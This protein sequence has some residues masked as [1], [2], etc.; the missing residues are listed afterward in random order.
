MGLLL[1]AGQAAAVAARDHG[2]TLTIG[3]VNNMPDTAWEATERQFVALVR[4]AAVK[5][6]VRLQLFSITDLPRADHVRGELAARYHDLSALLS[7]RLDGLIV[8]GTEPRAANLKDEP[9]WVRLATLID[10]ARHHTGSTIWSCLAAHAAVLHADGIER[11]PVAE[12]QFGVFDC[13][14]VSADPLTEGAGPRPAVPHSRWND[15]PEEALAACGYR[16]LTRSA[17]AGV[18]MFAGPER[19]FDSL[20]LFLQG[21]PEY[22]PG[23]LLRE[24]R[25]DIGRFLRGEQA[26]YPAMPQGYFN[27]T[28]SALASAFRERAL[29]ERR[30][31]LIAD[32]PMRA[33]EAGLGARWQRS[34]VAVYEKWLDYL[35]ERKADRRTVT[36]APQQHARGNWR[37]GTMRPAADGSSAG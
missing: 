2:D 30:A 1:D 36:V 34:A 29:S 8:T 5:T 17:A 14:V 37:L 11:R 32:F 19:S 20:F 31:D 18:D 35:K 28:A 16:I 33:L 6:P 22:E 15:L 23:T 26:H 4:A 25:R 7:M 12:K 10:W 21:H 9:Y 13:E 27:A 24:Y 3:L